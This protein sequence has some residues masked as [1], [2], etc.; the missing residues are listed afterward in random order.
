MRQRHAIILLEIRVSNINVL[1][2]VLIN[3]EV[4][5]AEGSRNVYYH[6]LTSDL[7]NCFA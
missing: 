5:S 7:A 4:S 3:A 6:N 2:M 1:C